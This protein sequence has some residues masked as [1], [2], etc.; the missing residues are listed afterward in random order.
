ME[1]RH[2][3]GSQPSV[4]KMTAKKTEK[5]RE[6]KVIKETFCFRVERRLV[7]LNM[8]ASELASSTGS[9]RSTI[10]ELLSPDNMRLPSIASLI[11]IAR[12]L[13]VNVSELLPEHFL[14]IDVDFHQKRRVFFPH[15]VASLQQTLDLI[16]RYS[17]QSG[18]FYH[19][20]TIPEFL[21]S[22]EI[23]SVEMGVPMESLTQYVAELARMR[24]AKLAGVLIIDESVLEDLIDRKGIYDGL[25]R[26]VSIDTVQAIRQFEA[27][28]E[29][30]ITLRLCNRLRDKIDPILILN[31]DVAISDYFGSLLLVTDTS[32]IAAA[33]ER[34]TQLCHAG[35]SLE[36]WLKSH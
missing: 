32:L 16:S 9:P 10:S 13:S 35:K 31:K 29:R 12:A 2:V 15:G 23:L 21:K 17:L 26:Q 6:L 27:D 34:F 20:R 18:I 7:D 22:P 1:T 5:S 24:E 33:E 14:S 19:P 30:D 4:P 11:N 8:T 3:S 25:S 28:Y 36:D